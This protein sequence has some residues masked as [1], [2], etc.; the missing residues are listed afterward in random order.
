M[1]VLVVVASPEPHLLSGWQVVG[2]SRVVAWVLCIFLL[3]GF[4]AWK[5]ETSES[6]TASENLEQ[7]YVVVLV[8]SAVNL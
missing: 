1:V 7:P 8:V 4:D 5:M 3:C 2:V 6:L